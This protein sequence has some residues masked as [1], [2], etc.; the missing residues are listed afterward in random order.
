MRA[1]IHYAFDS[2]LRKF[3]EGYRLFLYINSSFR[4]LA[5]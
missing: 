1:A 3:H 4:S 2:F 5:A